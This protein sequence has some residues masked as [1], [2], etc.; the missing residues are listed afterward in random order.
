MPQLGAGELLII[1]VIISL[2]FGAGKLPHVARD[3]THELREI[4]TA[5]ASEPEAPT[6]QER[7]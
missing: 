3:L 5:T 4:R 1:L 7:Y 2:V 6:P